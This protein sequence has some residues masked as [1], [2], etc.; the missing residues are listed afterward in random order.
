MKKSLEEFISS[1]KEIHNNKYDYSLVEYINSSTKVKIF[2]KKCN[3]YFEQLP[4]NHLSQKQGCPICGGTKKSNNED[5]IKKSNNIHNNT[6]DYSLTIYK[7]TNSKVKI[8]CKEHDIFE[9]TPHAHLGQKQGCP[10]CANKIRRLKRIK[11]IEDNKS[12]GYQIIPNFNKDAC[13]I[14]D[15]I[16]LEKGIH[17]QHAM[18]GGEYYIKEL[19]YWLDGYDKENNIVYEF[20][21]KY[22]EY[23]KEK[24]L[25][26]QKEI[27][28]Y[29][30]CE[31]IR[32]VL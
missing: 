3:E 28:H 27:E 9:Q 24:D 15:Y 29:L 18:N 32:I 16:S 25:I 14:F 4:N 20:D 13:E 26:R 21:E 19:G 31:F 2:C 1:S 7:N 6:Y 23:K 8:I 10:K 17:I 12:N 30:N 22:H 11:N 5:F